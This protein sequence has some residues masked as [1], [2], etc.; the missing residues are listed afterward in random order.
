MDWRRILS[1]L[2]ILSV[3]LL[4]ASMCSSCVRDTSKIV[5]WEDCSQSLGD[6]PCDFTLIDQHGNEF[7]LYDH[8]GKYIIL[9]LSAMW[10]GPCQFAATE[11]EE[12]QQKYGDDIVYVTILIEN[13][14]GNPPTRNNVADWA[15]IFSIESAPAL[16]ASRNFISSD[17]DEGWPLAAWPQFHIIDRNMVLIESF[18]GVRAGLMESKIVDLLNNESE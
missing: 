6:H 17:P 16:G 2:S 8:H 3:I 7:N 5:D 10:C 13:G 14:S 1:I 11:V 12:L 4:W 9:D 15:E 18:K